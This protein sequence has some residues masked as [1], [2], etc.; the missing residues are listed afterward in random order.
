[1]LKI[2][3]S[4]YKNAAV[5]Y[6]LLVR[7]ITVDLLENNKSA[8]LQLL[9][10][11][12]KNTTL[13][14]EEL[15]L[16]NLLKEQKIKSEKKA[17]YLI[18][19]VLESRRRLN[20]K[21]LRKEKYD[22]I[23]EIKEKYNIKDFLSTKIKEYRLL[24]S[25]YKLFET[26]VN[27]DKNYNPASII[28]C[29]YI[30]LENMT[31]PLKNLQN[32]NIDETIEAYKKQDKEIKMLSYKII[33]ENFNKKYGKLNINQ[34]KLLR[35]YVDNLSNTNLLKEHIDEEIPKIKRILEYYTKKISNKV[36]KIKLTELCK[37]L[38]ELKRGKIINE[39]QLITILKLYGLI[40]EIKKTINKN[41][42]SLYKIN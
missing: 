24:G 42:L 5:L 13:L 30:I 20:E 37:H 16:Y 39:D 41:E 8:A 17:D 7:Q 6:E 22:L 38:N 36:F 32:K 33:V 29:R 14:N 27:K 12:F 10:K 2:K 11:Y 19:E 21:I 26:V 34:R 4:K 9:K 1:M 3:H 25:I 28:T 35:K 18:N 31:S 23:K 15:M 40:E